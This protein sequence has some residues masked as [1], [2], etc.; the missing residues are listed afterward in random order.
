MSTVTIGLK[1]INL[2]LQC[3][4][5]L[6][7]DLKAELESSKS[8]QEYIKLMSTHMPAEM[9]RMSKVL[10]EARELIHK[11]LEAEGPCRGAGPE[12]DMCCNS[13]LCTYC[14]MA[15]SQFGHD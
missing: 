6:A 5:Q 11:H 15:R 3:Q 12:D 10:T 2:G 1:G 9:S 13:S 7:K 14:A 8:D 4:F